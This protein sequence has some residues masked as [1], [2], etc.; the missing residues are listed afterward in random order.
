MIRTAL[1]FLKKELDAYIA[2]REN[3]V[4]YTPGNIVDLKSVV[5]IGAEPEIDASKHIV[6]MLIGIEEE[7]REGKTPV[8]VPVDDKEYY[9]FNPPVSIDLNVL[10]IASAGNYATALR[11]LSSVICFFQANPVFDKN[12]NPDLNASVA[13]PVAKPWQT[14]DRLSCKIKNISIEQQNNIW[15][16]LGSKYVPSVV[17]KISALSAFETVGKEKV[18]AIL[19]RQFKDKVVH[20]DPA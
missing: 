11:D 3:D 2:N 12:R 15:S 10:F 6:I 19:E 7:I 1:E 18:A 9:R 4:Q 8:Y 14:I 13:D 17:Y 16:V 5:A 20:H